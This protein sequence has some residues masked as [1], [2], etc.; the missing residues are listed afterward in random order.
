MQERGPPFAGNTAAA[1]ERTSRVAYWSYTCH[2]LQNQYAEKS[3]N[4]RLKYA[5][6]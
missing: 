2:I 3:V 1:S 5:G 4:C 6:E